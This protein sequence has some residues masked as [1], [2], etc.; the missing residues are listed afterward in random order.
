MVV[1]SQERIYHSRDRR[2]T[3]HPSAQLVS[4][5][6]AQN[7]ERFADTAVEQENQEYAKGYVKGHGLAKNAGDTASCIESLAALHRLRDHLADEQEYVR[8]RRESRV[9][10]ILRMYQSISQ[11]VRLDMAKTGRVASTAVGTL[12]E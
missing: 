12:A 1:G 10:L 3:R 11:P 6:G 2:I 5:Q 9:L 7:V 8:I 4:R